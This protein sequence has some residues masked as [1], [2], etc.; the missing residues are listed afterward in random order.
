M[1]KKKKPPNNT[2]EK[3]YKNAHYTA[4]RDKLVSN[5][6][7]KKCFY[8]RYPVP[9]KFKSLDDYFLC[10]FHSWIRF[11][12]I[13]RCLNF[14]LFILKDCL[15]YASKPFYIHIFFLIVYTV[16]LYNTS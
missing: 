14:P 12:E 16:I 2:K 1:V 6:E 4:S 15:S 7:R 11:L 3:T 10:T 8:Y 9:L 5:K 13:V